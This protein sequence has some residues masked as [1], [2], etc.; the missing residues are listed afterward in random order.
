[1]VS[2]RDLG[3]ALAELG[4]MASHP[5]PG[6]TRGLSQLDYLLV[7]DSGFDV[8]KVASGVV[9]VALIGDDSGPWLTQ[10]WLDRFDLTLATSGGA[11]ESIQA[12][13][14][15][16]VHVPGSGDGTP[17][18][19]SALREILFRHAHALSFCLKI[20][21]PDW[22]AAERG[23]DLYFARSLRSELRRRGHPCRIQVQNE[24]E[25]G[26]GLQDDVAVVLRGRG[27]YRPKL[28]QLNILWNISHP[29]ELTARE[30][31]VYDL[32]CVA[33]S[34]FA[35][36][37]RGQTRTP[38][39]VLPQATDPR[40]F[41]PEPD[42]RFRHELAFVGNTRG[43]RRRI[44]EDAI[45]ASR[46]LA[47]YGAG[48]AEIIDPA[49]I[50]S[51]FV[52]NHELHRVYS[53]S[54]IVLCDHWDDMRAQGF[55]SNRVFD[56]LACGAPVISDDVPGLPALLGEGVL[57]Y[58]TREELRLL[59]DRLLADPAE[60]AR[61][62]TR[63]RELVLSAHTFAHRVDTLLSEVD[64]LRPTPGRPLAAAHL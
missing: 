35:E 14:L 27:S 39:I 58:R 30:C 40:V 48:W 32:V 49:L 29:D 41:F 13:G 24:W 15:T 2:E 18:G 50:V 42:P 21:A 17:L 1:M 11:V 34:G 36:R 25:D 53:S 28:G 10:P 61:L 4:W 3:T 22:T 59:I 54:S 8:G 60:R 43:V 19:V 52:P 64:Q 38:A 6:D 55:V 37:L 31:D 45:G 7:A 33:S 51:E 20:G 56:A 47:V 63:G 5:Q 46:D 57:T 16:A 62:G 44:V 12:A 9:V 26:E 23:G